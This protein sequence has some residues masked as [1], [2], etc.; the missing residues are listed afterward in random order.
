[1]ELNKIQNSKISELVLQT[2]FDSISE[3][4]IKLGEELPPERDLSE[5]LGIS[6]GS[7]RES[8]AILEFLGIIE[9]R[10]NRKVVVRDAER[11][12]K[13]LSIL[14]LSYQKDIFLDYLEFRR[15][16]EALAAELACLRATEEDIKKIKEAVKD[17]EDDP[18][19]IDAD[20]RFHISLAEAS[21]NVFLVA[22]EEFMVSIL[23]SSRNRAMQKP[24]RKFEIIKENKEI[25]NAIEQRD[26]KLAREKMLVHLSNIEQ[27]T[28]N[29]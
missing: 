9:N 13:T 18:E 7:L 2:I 22:I 1:M 29:S 12:K 21:H 19:N 16:V 11:V 15:A 3:G 17:L 20:Y 26:V 14:K 4:K 5:M 27:Y 24:G 10:G 6:R 23:E 25:V 28:K 8:L